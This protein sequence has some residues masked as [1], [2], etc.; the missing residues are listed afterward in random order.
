LKII[1]SLAAAGSRLRPLTNTRPRWLLP[2]ADNTIVG[3]MLDMM[4][5]LTA[6][7]VVFVVESGGEDV[8]QWV[9]SNY[10]HLPVHFVTPGEA[11]GQVEALWRC[12]ELLGKE[13][14][15]VAGGGAIMR[16]DFTGL[17]DTAA[18]VVCF[19]FPPAASD[20]GSAITVDEA[21]MVQQ[22]AGPL[23]A[24]GHALF[25]GV[26]WF[27]HGRALHH[28][29]EQ[30]MRRGDGRSLADALQFML[31]EGARVA[32]RTADIWL[33][34]GTPEQLLHANARLLGLGYCSE[35]AIER[36]YAEDFTVMPPVFLDETAEVSR[37][38]IGPY[39]S[40]GAGAKIRGAVIRN[41]IVG[42]GT[43]V[44]DCVLDGAMLGQNCQVSGRSHAPLAGDDSIVELG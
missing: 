2:V 21:G 1:I 30:T 22:F 37:S 3:H 28:A 17:P 39:A 34:T 12:R 43:V 13:D 4:P 15:L 36:S 23:A 26:C 44:N 33:E 6:A 10:P 16:A 19:T 18:D 41:S 32:A 8:E 9:C 25:T 31:E 5:T 27:R 14:V 35:D 29:L 7:E 20:T 42:A 38:V 11:A 40:I 24:A